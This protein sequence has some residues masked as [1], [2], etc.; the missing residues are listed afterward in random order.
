[1]NQSNNTK[2]ARARE[3]AQSA[4]SKGDPLGWF[5]TLYKENVSEG[6]IIPWADRVPNPHL[7]SW[8]QK[9]PANKVSGQKAL[10]I[11]CGLGD[12]AEYLAH[13]GYDVTAFDISTTA[14]SQCRARFPNS[15]VR[16]EVADLF[17]SPQIWRNAFDFVLES[18]TLQ[19]FRPDLRSRAIATISSYPSPNGSL[20]VIC[21]GREGSDDLGSMPWPL[22]KKE[23]ERFKDYGLDEV[24]FEDYRDTENPPVR[25]FRAHFRRICEPDGPANRGQPVRSETIRTSLA[26]D[27]GR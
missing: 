18:Y 6:T 12:D 25:R 7:I 17:N 20:L 4:I 27:P 1:M 21:R 10:K 13:L 2:R 22:T 8:I 16:Y 24:S 11:G 14:I 9:N 26:A 19:V 23:L 3:L 15:K 5:D